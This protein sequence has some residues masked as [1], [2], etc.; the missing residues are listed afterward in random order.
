MGTSEPE[1]V[2]SGHLG[3]LIVLRL[4]LGGRDVPDRSQPTITAAPLIA[5]NHRFA[6]FQLDPQQVADAPLSLVSYGSAS[7]ATHGVDFPVSGNVGRPLAAG[8]VRAGSCASPLRS[9]AVTPPAERPRPTPPASSGCWCL[10]VVRT[11]STVNPEETD[12]THHQEERARVATTL[13][14]RRN[15]HG[16]RR[17]RSEDAPGAGVSAAGGPFLS[18]LRNI[19]DVMLRLEGWPTR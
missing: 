9:R 6:R 8:W 7:L 3:L 2:K 15:H 4:E 13:A 18:N 17:R 14:R 12:A 16:D 5:G 10:F 19:K 11:H 1:F